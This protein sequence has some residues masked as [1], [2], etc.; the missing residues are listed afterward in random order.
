MDLARGQLIDGDF[1]NSGQA[2]L[3]SQEAYSGADLWQ[4]WHADDAQVA[5]A[6]SAAEAAWPLWSACPLDERRAALEQYALLLEQQKEELSK[7]I[8]LENGKPLWEAKTEAGAMIAKIAVTIESWNERC[9]EQEMTLG[10]A[11]GRT[12][13]KPLGVCAVLGPFN[14]PGHLPNGQIVPAILAGNSVVFK[15]SE[16]CPAVGAFLCGLLQQC[17]PAGVINLVQGDLRVGQSLLDQP[18]LAAVFFTGSYRGG[19]AIHR[20]FAGRPE[21]LLALE[22]GGNN[23]LIVWDVE[24]LE[25]AALLIVQSAYV[26]AGQRCVCARRLIIPSGSVGDRIIESLL[27]MIARMRYGDPMSADPVFM[28]GVIHENAALNVLKAQQALIDDGAQVLLKTEQVDPAHPSLLSPGLIDVSGLVLEDE[29]VFGP[30]LQV[31]RVDT[32]NQAIS[33]ANNTRYGLSAGL[34]SDDAQLYQQC[35]QQL[36]V[37]ILNWNRQIT[38]A[39]GRMPFGGVGFSGNHRPGAWHAVDFCHYPCASIE[40]A[41]IEMGAL[42]QGISDG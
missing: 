29:E 28:S 2:E 19:A 32:F 30:L 14:L 24:D 13:Q 39:S 5:A 27:K 31:Q 37:G 26:T 8:C 17:V 38:G 34:V 12:R 3:H 41:Q 9:S 20:H 35:V 1:V 22:M 11:I 18:G 25:T 33:L 4:G 36:R 21:I 10:S 6:V 42:P 16:Q 15:P 40:Q 7:L 23:P